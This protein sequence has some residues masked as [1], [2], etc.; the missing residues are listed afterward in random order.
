MPYMNIA[1]DKLIQL[2]GS[3]TEIAARLGITPQTVNQW[4]P[5]NPQYHDIGI[6]MAVSIERITEGAV[7][8]IDCRP[9]DYFDYWPDLPLPK[10]MR[11][12]AA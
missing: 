2:Y 12:R 11:G 9:L 4:R 6:K 1:Y 3:Q 5:G 8:R 7:T 10:K